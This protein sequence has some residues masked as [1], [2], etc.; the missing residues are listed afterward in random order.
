MGNYTKQKN[1]PALSR[2]ERGYF[3]IPT[4][5]RKN[6]GK[7]K[8]YIY[9]IIISA[10]AMNCDHISGINLKK[11]KHHT[12]KWGHKTAVRIFTK[13][14]FSVGFWQMQSHT[15]TTKPESKYSRGL[16]PGVSIKNNC[17][18]Y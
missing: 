11:T 1:T 14:Y 16:I 9:P 17:T 18:T 2:I 13:L 3:A 12:T 7:F 6:K 8:I 10:M 5:Q 15:H 4:K